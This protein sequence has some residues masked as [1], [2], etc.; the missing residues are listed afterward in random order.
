[1]KDANA[2]MTLLEIYNSIK[3]SEKCITPFSLVTVQEFGRLSTFCQITFT[4]ANQKQIKI[5]WCHYFSYSGILSQDSSEKF[6]KY[7]K[8]YIASSYV[9]YIESAGARVVPIRYP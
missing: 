8:S 1:M 6:S 5:C 2:A 9:K 7:G 4:Q 3:Y